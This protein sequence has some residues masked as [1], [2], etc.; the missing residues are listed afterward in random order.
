MTV[1]VGYLI[2]CNNVKNSCGLIIIIEIKEYIICPFKHVLNV[3]INQ[4]VLYYK[5]NF[6]QRKRRKSVLKVTR[7]LTHSSVPIVGIEG[8]TQ[9]PLTELYSELEM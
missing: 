6:K 4:L 2:F 5:L 8:F 7:R 3:K 1:K 9:S